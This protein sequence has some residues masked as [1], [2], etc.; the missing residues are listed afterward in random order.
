MSID[1]SLPAATRAKAYKLL[2]VALLVAA[3][4]VGIGL[5]ATL[6]V[7][8]IEV[9]MTASGFDWIWLVAIAIMVVDLGLA[10]HFWRRA[11]AIESNAPPA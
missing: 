10:A 9:A 3:V 11:E 2:A 1:P 8:H 6:Y 5:P 7:M 4:I